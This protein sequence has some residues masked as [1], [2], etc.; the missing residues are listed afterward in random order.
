MAVP[1]CRCLGPI[2]G[3]RSTITV[4]DSLLSE[5]AEAATRPDYRI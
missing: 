3:P 2:T 4:S 1:P 5:K